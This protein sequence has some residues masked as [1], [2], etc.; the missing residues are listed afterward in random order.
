M[1][2]VRPIAGPPTNASR[3]DVPTAAPPGVLLRPPPVQS[4]SSSP[5]DAS[6]TRPVWGFTGSDRWLLAVSLAIMAVLLSAH[7]WR[8]RDRGMKPVEII[9]PEGKY[10]FHV[11]LN[12]ATWV[13]WAQLDGIGEKLARRIVADREERGPFQSPEDLLRV[14]GIGP[15]T[16]DKMRPYLVID[17]AAR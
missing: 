15:K 6:E 7:M 8:D 11:A 4:G 10:Q 12:S 1:P 2:A 17:E 14:K 3:E 13:E 5:P 9:H 16:L